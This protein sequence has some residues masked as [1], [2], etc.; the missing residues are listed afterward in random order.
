MFGPTRNCWSLAWHGS[1]PRVFWTADNERGFWKRWT[2]SANLIS[3]P[4]RAGADDGVLSIPRRRWRQRVRHL[5][6]PK[7]WLLWVL[8]SNNLVTFAGARCVVRAPAM[9]PAKTGTQFWWRVRAVKH[10]S[11]FFQLSRFFKAGVLL[12]TIAAGALLV[13]GS[14]QASF[15][16]EIGG[17]AGTLV[18]RKRSGLTLC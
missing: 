4:F 14:T 15:N 11:S 16:F 6:E 9:H 17:L 7:V 1:H 10:G 12:T 5:C 2:L 18:E 8:R 3:R 13:L